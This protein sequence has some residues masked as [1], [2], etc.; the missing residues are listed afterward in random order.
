MNGLTVVRGGGKV[1][2]TIDM[3]V[4]AG[5][6]TALLGVNG[7]GKS[8][9]IQAVAG[10]LPAAGGSVAL[11]GTL[12]HTL[13]AEQRAKLGIGLS[14]EGRR[15]FPGMTVGDNL[16]AVCRAGAKVRRERVAAVYELFPQLAPRDRTLAWQL[17][18]GQQQML[19][20]GRA[21]MNLPRLLVLDEPTLGLAPAVIFDLM[22][23]LTWVAASGTAILVA[24][25]NAAVL[26]IAHRCCVMRVG[27]IV[28]E[29]TGADLAQD[30]QRLQAAMLGT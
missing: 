22:E 9:L 4:E 18:G 21:L 1:V 7:A 10:L 2:D 3:T 8:S 23:R 28:L 30:P 6:V 14:P 13:P 5:T 15:V 26:S 25:Q 20:I 19:A 27:R 17:S 16:L 29:T 24:E 11:A 12:I